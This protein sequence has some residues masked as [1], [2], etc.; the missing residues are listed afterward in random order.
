MKL[1]GLPLKGYTVKD[2]KLEPIKRRQSVSEIIRQK[3]SKR[4]RVVRKSKA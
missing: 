2:G 3:S 4:V 1:S